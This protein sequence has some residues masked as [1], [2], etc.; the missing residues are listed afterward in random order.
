MSNTNLAMRQL[1]EFQSSL[2]K[3]LDPAHREA[4]QHTGEAPVSTANTG[5]QAPGVIAAIEHDGGLQ[6]QSDINGLLE[7]NY[8]QRLGAYSG[9]QGSIHE[10][11]SFDTPVVG[12]RK[13]DNKELENNYWL[14]K[15]NVGS[16]DAVQQQLTEAGGLS[17][18][19]AMEAQALYPAFDGG[20]NIGFYTTHVS[21]QRF[22]PAFES[23]EIAYRNTVQDL[24]KLAQDRLADIFMDSINYHDQAIDSEEAQAFVAEQVTRAV[25][26]IEDEHEKFQYLRSYMHTLIEFFQTQGL[27]ATTR[28]QQVV[29]FD[30]LEQLAA[31]LIPD[32]SL[33]FKQ[34]NG[35]HFDVVDNGRWSQAVLRL[36]DQVSS[37]M[38]QARAQL[39]VLTPVLD[40]LKLSNRYNP[41]LVEALQ[42]LKP[43][44]VQIDTLTLDAESA[45]GEIYQYGLTLEAQPARAAPSIAAY[46]DSLTRVTEVQY[47]QAV[48]EARAQLAS[49]VAEVYQRVYS[50]VP[51]LTEAG[52]LD[53]ASPLARALVVVDERVMG[54]IKVAHRL[55][56]QFNA[57]LACVSSYSLQGVAQLTAVLETLADSIQ[58]AKASVPGQ[59]EAVQRALAAFDIKDQPMDYN[60]TKLSTI[61]GEF[62]PTTTDDED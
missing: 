12:V 13:I 1:D 56:H 8:A 18:D 36:T 43:L 11:L 26:A 25:K 21:K 51:I 35:L 38:Y 14:F 24:V 10:G 54:W 62:T 42:Q 53:T 9:S 34:L 40:Q 23:V 39:G 44:T 58:A 47:R 41:E 59:L 33:N 45:I 20:R 57:W 50:G 15:T 22:K 46:T 19:I 7:R 55:I 61:A 30:D 52:P 28:D 6:N 4:N 49:F 48:V 32:R 31:C 3:W 60:A 16:L 2:N 5:R 29:K 27:E 17:K 37:L